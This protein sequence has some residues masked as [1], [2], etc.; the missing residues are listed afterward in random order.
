MKLH[1]IELKNF[2]QF[3][4]EK[5]LD[6]STEKAKNVTVVH[7]ENGVGK[8][9]LLNAVL[10]TF[11]GTFTSK[12][13]QP[14]KVINFEAEKQG[15]TSA[16]VGVQFEQEGVDYR[17]Q[18]HFIKQLGRTDDQFKVFRTDKG[19]LKDLPHPEAFVNSVIPEEMAKYFFFDGEQAEA[20]S[21]H[22]NFEAVGE[23]VRD[24]LGFKLAEIAVEDLRFAARQIAKGVSAVSS[25][26][27]RAAE[28]EYEKILA[29][30]ETDHETLKIETANR[31]TLEKQIDAIVK[32]LRESEGAALLQRQREDKER[33]KKAVDK[34]RDDA[35]AELIRWIGRKS[36][37]LLA[38]KLSSVSLSFIDEESLRGRIPS[39][40]NEEFVKGLISAEVCVCERPLKHGTAEWRAVAR[41]L[42][43]AANAQTLGRVVSAR[44]RLNTLTE[45]RKEA[46][47]LLKQIQNRVV[48]ATEARN[49]LE[50]EISEIHDKIKSLPLAEIAEKEKAR[51][52]LQKQLRAVDEKIGAIQARLRH[53]E[54]DASDAKRRI[55]DLSK[56]NEKA[57]K[58]IH[59]R[60]FA[61]SAA[62]HL[63]RILKDHETSARGFIQKLVNNALDTVTRKDYKFKLNEDFSMDLIQ[64]GRPVPR[65]SGENQLMTLA[66]TA[67]LAEFS[68]TR[69]RADGILLPG[70]VAPLV[71]DSPFGQLDKR[72]RKDTARFVPEMAEQVVVFLSSSQGTEEVMQALRPRIGAEYVLISENRAPRGNKKREEIRIGN[73]VIETSLYGCERDLTRIERLI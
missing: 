46:P 19:V 34:Q 63:E 61:E 43:N 66:F 13:A 47:T 17:A 58:I 10:W 50:Q 56:N 32:Q 38:R 44:G 2:R 30:Q 7:A 21:D 40:Y 11:Y 20:F 68:R 54:R 24:M 3:Y 59:K 14:D 52:E 60:E 53:S 67:A 8:T 4:G 70:I 64:E 6:I 41:L 37:A 23:A 55:D 22:T 45:N 33:D 39:P 36:L 69:S 18:R 71:L 65:S 51:H 26:E 12:L 15:K 9:T 73:N 27:V 5:A 72:Y 31:S 25:V 42:E 16:S 62:K 49:R 29:R 48:Q 1:R 28:A 35:Q 57:Q